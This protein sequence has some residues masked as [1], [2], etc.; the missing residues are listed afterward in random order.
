MTSLW[1]SRTYQKKEGKIAFFFSKSLYVFIGYSIVSMQHA[2]HY[3]SSPNIPS[4]ISRSSSTSTA[5]TLFHFFVG[6]TVNT[7]SSI[8]FFPALISL[9]S[10]WISACNDFINVASPC[11]SSANFSLPC[12][13]S[14]FPGTV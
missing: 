5:A 8:T 10:F 2:I 13:L 14:F 1:R 9:I 6:A 12:I 3:T 4:S 7:S 11:K